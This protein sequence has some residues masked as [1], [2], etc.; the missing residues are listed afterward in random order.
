MDLLI[1][2]VAALTDGCPHQIFGLKLRCESFRCPEG[3]TVVGGTSPRLWGGV[4]LLHHSEVSAVL[5]EL[6]LRGV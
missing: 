1:N 6:Q 2:L 3:I 5:L 4:L